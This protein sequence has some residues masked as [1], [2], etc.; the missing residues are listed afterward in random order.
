LNGIQK[1]SVMSG[2]MIAAQRRSTTIETNS[3]KRARD[4]SLQD[5]ED[6]RPSTK[7]P[8]IKLRHGQVLWLLTELGY[9]GTVSKSAFFEYIKSLRKLGIPFG[10]EKFHT[11]QGKRLARY[12]FCHVMEL[13][14]A[15]SLRVYHV[16]PDAV[17]K[18]IV[19]YRTHL[20]RCYRRAYAERHRGTGKST[21]IVTE[22]CQPVELRG[23]YLDLNIEFAGGQLVRFGPP[24]LLSSS[25]TLVRFSK[26]PNLGRAFLPLAL[27]FLSEQVSALALRAPDVRSGPPTPI[28]AARLRIRQSNR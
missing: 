10:D 2:V 4:S 6:D 19:D 25:E 1:R 22:D 14:L 13:A 9:R 16:V 5:S 12:S 27:S 20:H 21:F 7:L 11:N 26:G 24:R 17:L 18:G 3:R 28:S 23:L 15:L 8:S